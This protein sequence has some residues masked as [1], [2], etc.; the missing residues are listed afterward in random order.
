MSDTTTTT[1]AGV[2]STATGSGG[3]LSSAT[4]SDTS[5]ASAASTDTTTAAAPSWTNDR[6]EFSEGWQGRV[7]GLT[8]EQQ[9]SLGKFKTPDAL[10][11]SFVH[12][13]RKLGENGNRVAIPGE[14]S[15]PEDV[16]AFRK[17]LGVPDT[18]DGYKI[19]TPEGVAL[20]QTTLQKATELA[21]K[22]N[23]PPA[24]LQELVGLQV[25]MA[26]ASQAETVNQA[27]ARDTAEREALG[28]AWGADF[29][30]KEH[31]V[32]SAL[33]LT[34]IDQA[35]FTD[36]RQLLAIERLSAMISDSTLKVGEAT[37][38]FSNAE[39]LATEIM[40]NPQH[41]DNAAYRDASH[42]NHKAV[43]GKVQDLIKA[44]QARAGQR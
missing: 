3:L 10:A 26:K 16:A 27:I 28:K 7:E 12:L 15:S 1:G 34:G 19:T 42:P 2:A 6:G 4:T 25:E 40:S 17:A 32:T 29:K 30:Q 9:V 41:P 23:I 24:A 37:S 13:E 35:V 33:A 31:R 20:N 38:N 36:H 39:G 11:K 22:H 21:H 44:G 14:N 43:R 5:Q 18:V 8:P